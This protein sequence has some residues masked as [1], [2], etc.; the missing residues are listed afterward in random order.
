MDTKNPKNPKNPPRLPDFGPWP[1][2]GFV[3]IDKMRAALDR[4]EQ[5]VRNLV[6]EKLLPP[7]VAIGP[8]RVG[9]P[10]DVARQAIVALPGLLAARRRPVRGI[11]ARGRAVAA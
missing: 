8:N 6:D 1:Q 7:L 2:V 4:S 3:G 5:G 9:W 11:G 10:V